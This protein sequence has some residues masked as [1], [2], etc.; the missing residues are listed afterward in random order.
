[1]IRFPSI[2]SNI[3]ERKNVIQ[4][5]LNVLVL[6]KLSHIL[7]AL[8]RIVLKVDSLASNYAY[9]M[10]YNHSI[11]ISHYNFNYET[12]TSP[13]SYTLQLKSSYFQDISPCIPMKVS[14]R[15]GG[16]ILLYVLR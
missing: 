12:I 11:R 9:S 7:S 5:V 3:K 4:E 10:P 6:L 13:A 16:N 2:F 15:F 8:S 14:R 1:M